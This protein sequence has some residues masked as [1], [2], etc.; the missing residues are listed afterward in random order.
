[1]HDVLHAHHWRLAHASVWQNLGLMPLYILHYTILGKY[2]T[3]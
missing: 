1:V 2:N 3:V